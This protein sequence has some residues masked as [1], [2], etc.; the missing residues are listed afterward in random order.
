MIIGSELRT[1]LLTQTSITDIVSG[2]IHAIKL[3]KGAIFP[4]ITYNVVS[5]VRTYSHSG[6]SS[7]TRPRIQYSCWA[8]LIEDAKNLALALTDV[9][10]GFKGTAGM[11]DVQDSFVEN[12]VDMWDAEARIYHVPVDILIRYNG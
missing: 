4:A 8:E 11:A 9:L 1:Y 7:L 10:S 3:P 12:E 6:D 5:Q 2:R